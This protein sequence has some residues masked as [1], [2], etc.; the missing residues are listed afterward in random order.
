MKPWMGSLISWYRLL[1]SPFNPFALAQARNYAKCKHR[2]SLMPTWPF[3]LHEHQCYNDVMNIEHHNNR[4]PRRL[5]VRRPIVGD[6]TFQNVSFCV[7]IGSFNTHFGSIPSQMHRRPSYE[8]LQNVTECD[9][10]AGFRAR[11]KPV[12]RS[13]R[14]VAGD[15]AALLRRWRP[16][17]LLAP[18][19]A[20]V[21]EPAQ[22]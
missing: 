19:G 13:A 14:G 20:Y 2:C 15:P 1:T 16:A 18:A 21:A 7:Q 12:A 6:P 3:A 5:S 11:R 17:P 8:M 10:S 4:A 9:T 22:R